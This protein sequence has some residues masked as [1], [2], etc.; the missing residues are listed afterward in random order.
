MSLADRK[1]TIVTTLIAA[2]V[3]VI[4]PIAA[5][6]GYAAFPIGPVG[7]NGAT[8]SH[9]QEKVI[10]ID[11]LGHIAPKLLEFTVNRLRLRPELLNNA[12][13]GPNIPIPMT[14]PVVYICGIYLCFVDIVE[15][16]S[17]LARY[18]IQNRKQYTINTYWMESL[19]YALGSSHVI[20]GS[21][22]KIIFKPKRI[23]ICRSKGAST[24]IWI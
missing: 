22:R 16:Q 5:K 1:E 3:A 11:K 13:P 19:R 15:V 24:K 2:V 21:I 9:Q 17:L 7:A 20:R 18:Q 8:I 4:T 6:T 12:R 23:I 10:V 14:M